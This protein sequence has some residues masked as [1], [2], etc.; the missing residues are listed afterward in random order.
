MQLHNLN[1]KEIFEFLSNR[2]IFQSDY[3]SKNHQVF[4]HKNVKK[5]EKF[6]LEFPELKPLKLEEI[7]QFQ[8]IKM[9]K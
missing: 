8:S 1:M 3:F 9:L 6:Y 2:E 7:N 5:I 4:L